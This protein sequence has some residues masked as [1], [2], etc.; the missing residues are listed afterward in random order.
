MFDGDY[1]SA[2]ET[3]LYISE[4]MEFISLKFVRESLPA[5]KTYL[6]PEEEDKTYEIAN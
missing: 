1:P 6:L 3:V 4:S 2:L 5:C